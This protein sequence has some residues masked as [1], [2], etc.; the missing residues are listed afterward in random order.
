MNDFSAFIN[1][2]DICLS[3]CFYATMAGTM[4]MPVIGAKLLYESFFQVGKPAKYAIAILFLAIAGSLLHT[5]QASATF[6]AAKGETKVYGIDRVSGNTIPSSN[7]VDTLRIWPGDTQQVGWRAS[8]WNAGDIGNR[9]AGQI[10]GSTITVKNRYFDGTTSNGTTRPHALVVPDVYWNDENPAIV[11]MV[12]AGLSGLSYYFGSDW[13]T[14]TWYPPQMNLSGFSGVTTPGQRFCQY[15]SANPAGFNVIPWGGSYWGPNILP[16]PGSGRINNRDFDSHMACAEVV[17]VYNLM[18]TITFNNPGAVQAGGTTATITPK[19]DQGSLPSG[20]PMATDSER[21]QWRITQ[22]VIAAG[23]PRP[24]AAGG[25]SSQLPCSGTAIAYFKPTTGSGP[26][27]CATVA[28]SGTS[29]NRK[30]SVFDTAGNIR[31]GGSALPSS[32]GVVGTIP[33]GATVCYALSVNAYAPSYISGSA[34]WRHSALAC[35]TPSNYSLLPNATPVGSAVRSGGS[36]SV[37]YAVDVR[38]NSTGGTVT[39]GWSVMRVIV[40]PGNG[41]ELPIRFGQPGN[42]TCG[43]ASDPYCDNMNCARVQAFL[44]SSYEDCGLSPGGVNSCTTSCETYALADKTLLTRQENIPDQLEI[45]T[46]VC[47]ILTLSSPANGASNRYSPA[48]CITVGKSPSVQVWGGDVRVG[49]LFFGDGSGH[50]NPSLSSIY[51]TNFSMP[52]RKRYGSWVEYGAFAPGGIFA[53]ASLAGFAQGYGGTSIAADIACDDRRLNGLTFANS[54]LPPQPHA[55]ECGHFGA[56]GSIPRTASILASRELAGSGVPLTN[57]NP[58][59]LDMSVS[60]R[61]EVEGSGDIVIDGSTI[62]AGRKIILDVEDRN[63]TINGD[64][65][66]ENGSGSN[67]YDSI[68]EIPQLVI[69]A[70]NITIN[71]NVERVDAWLIANGQTTPSDGTIKTCDIASPA[72]PVLNARICDKQLKINGPIMARYL[73]LWRTYGAEDSRNACDRDA[74]SPNCDDA[75]RSAEIINLPGSSLLWA[76]QSPADMKARTTYTVELPPYF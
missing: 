64:I 54:I 24:N 15:A 58:L 49:R 52:D 42:T 5:N 2:F 39:T 71:R 4:R 44:G 32:V 17:R 26:I 43:S 3:L 45:G 20:A 70:K 22:V 76:A 21:A 47:F 36:T 60:G 63:V 65:E 33:V 38:D 46:K 50:I 74:F 59:R 51:T 6:F 48:A 62:V 12:T 75:R 1:G 10:E 56:M 68:S 27:T 25:V 13:S 11:G 73:Q 67:T 40:K 31:P 37:T 66:Y 23:T 30:N 7:P 8:V 57:T 34:T 41:S 53:T 9:A 16:I 28:E 55:T 18:P 69:I 61:Y 72:S 19:V 35:N 29:A 14:K